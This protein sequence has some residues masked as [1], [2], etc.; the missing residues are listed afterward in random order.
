M[1]LTMHARI[2]DRIVLGIATQDPDVRDG[3][4]F[5]ETYV[6]T[7]CGFVEWYCL[8]PKS[9]PLGPEYMADLVTYT[10]DGPFR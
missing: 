1:S 7:T 9:I 6:C 3:A 2:V 5:V 4:G 10:T 8:N